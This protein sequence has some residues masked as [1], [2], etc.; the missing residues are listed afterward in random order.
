VRKLHTAIVASGVLLLALLIYRIGP[1]SLWQNLALLGWGFLSL[2]LL[3]GMAEFFHTHA[4]RHC[5]SGPHRSLPF[6][7]VFSIRLAGSSINHLTPFAGLGGEVTKGFLLASSE[8]GPEAATA[9]IVDKLSVALAQLIFVVGGSLA[10]LWKIAL[11]RSLWIALISGTA[12][13][14]GGVIGFLV[15]QKYGKLGGLVRWCVAHRVGGSGLEKAARHMTHVDQA[16]QSFYRTRPL[17]LPLATFWHILGMVWSIIP[18]FYFLALLTKGAS[19]SVAAA[20]VCLGTWFNLVTFALPV[21]IGVQEATRLIIFRMLGF[22]SA[23]G[24]TYGITIRLEQFCWA[25]IGLAVYAIL[26][27]KMR[28][29]RIVLV[30]GDGDKNP[31]K[32][33]AL[34]RRG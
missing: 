34:W 26:V 32:R 24:L 25:G 31:K 17:D 11:P 15:V 19:L 10:V 4:W 30:K 23:L 3:D 28:K 16:L 8:T 6:F 12:L 5:L 2:T 14:A 20:V 9:V 21:D 27:L 7:R 13:L 29:G 1:A 33:E 18:A 22:P